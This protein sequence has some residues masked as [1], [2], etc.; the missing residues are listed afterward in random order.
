MNWLTDTAYIKTAP[1]IRYIC[2]NHMSEI[3]AITDT[4]ESYE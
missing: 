2:L 4:N 1:L 3:L